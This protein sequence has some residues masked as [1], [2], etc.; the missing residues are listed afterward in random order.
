MTEYRAISPLVEVSGAAVLAVVKGMGA[1]EATA[2]RLLAEQGIVDPRENSWH[3]QQAWLNAFRAIADNI[4]PATLTQI[5]RKIPETAHW[6]PVIRTV[7]AALASIDTAY[8]LNHRGGEIGHYRFEQTGTGAG[9]VV[10]DNPYPCAF[11]IGII[12]AT[13]RHFSPQ[14]VFLQVTHDD[15]KPCRQKGGDSCTYQVVW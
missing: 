13:A 1:F 6:P 3:P 15:S 2:R 4:G 12:D 9:C 5:G 10:C 14:G 11:D 7:E 8:H